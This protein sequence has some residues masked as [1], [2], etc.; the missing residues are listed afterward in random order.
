MQ[1][2]QI[3]FPARDALAARFMDKKLGNAFKVLKNG[4][5]FVH[6]HNG[7]RAYAQTGFPKVR[8]TV[9]RVQLAGT[10]YMAALPAKV[11]KF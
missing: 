9:N 1:K 2:V 6:N 7:A 8:I 10:A 3:A 5:T 4:N 11:E